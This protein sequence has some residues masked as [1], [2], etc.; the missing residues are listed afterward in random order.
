MSGKWQ[1]NKE[2]YTVYGIGYTVY[3]LRFTVHGLI[4]KECY[5]VFALYRIP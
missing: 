3:G 5:F 2:G 4:R 1:V